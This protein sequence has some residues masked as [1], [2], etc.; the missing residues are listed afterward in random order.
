MN[1]DHLDRLNHLTR[2]TLLRRALL[3]AGGTTT[4][5]LLAACGEAATSAPATVAATV[6]PTVGSAPAPTVASTAAPTTAPAA[7]GAAA[8]S[9]VP[10]ASTAPAMMSAVATTGAA[11]TSAPAAVVP[12]MTSATN[13]KTIPELRVAVAAMPDG[14]DSLFG[15]SNV[16]NRANYSLYDYL[17]RVD[18]TKPTFTLAPMLATEWKRADD[19]TL[20]VTLRSGATF[21]DGSPVTADDVVFTFQRIIANKDPKYGQANPDYFPLAGVTR[22]DDT[23]VRFTSAF[24]D[25]LFERRLATPG[26]QII[27]AKYFQQVGADV[28]ATKPLGSGP[29][30]VTEFAPG[31]HI[32]YEAYKGYWGGAPAA[33]KLTIRVV[34]EVASRIAAVTNGEV[35]IATNVPPDQVAS[36]MARKN[37]TVKG[38]P[39]T[40]THMLYFNQKNKPFDKPEIRQAMTYAIDRKTLVDAIWLG[41]AQMMHGLQFEGEDLYNP[42]RPLTAYDPD[43]AKALLK[44]GGYAG[45]EIQ[46]IAATPNYYTNE[47][48]AG[49]AIIG[50]WKQAGINGKLNLVE[51]AQKPKAIMTGHA[52]TI[53]ATSF[54]GDQE[55]YVWQPLGPNGSWQKSGY[56]TPRGPFNQ[57]GSDIR[58]TLDRQKRYD[59][60]QQMLDIFE[61]EAPGTVLYQPKEL[62]AVANT[63]EW[64]PYTY[65]YMDLRPY[66][67]RVK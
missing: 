26:A 17:I 38:R 10:A 47:R 24:V 23:H 51:L 16:L 3:A 45:E 53:S 19:K 64:E 28:F 42:N 35:E 58:M 18:Y 13:G 14:L 34:P 49:E 43:K 59:G 27:S 32:S 22:V 50:M 52:Y 9:I 8:P 55:G 11:A 20:D 15:S 36:L 54:I 67:F 12:T 61:A 31:D 5:A 60:F 6:S 48:E 46:Y 33:N 7:T 65:Y 37:L 44:Q 41:N 25:P 39:L 4:A 2:R 56:W 1:T 29:Y 66:N 63:I 40:N 57:L 30:R 62:Y 21:Q